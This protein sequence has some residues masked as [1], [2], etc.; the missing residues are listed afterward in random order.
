[1]QRKVAGVLYII[2]SE[3]TEWGLANKQLKCESPFPI[4][5]KYVNYDQKK[6]IP[7]PQTQTGIYQKDD[8]NKAKEN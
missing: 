6:D 5:V 7:S 3:M 1:M 8:G 4:A 2:G